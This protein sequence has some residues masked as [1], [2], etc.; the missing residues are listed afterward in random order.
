M[1]RSRWNDPEGRELDVLITIRIISREDTGNALN[2]LNASRA[3]RPHRD[4]STHASTQTRNRRSDTKNPRSNTKNSRPSKASRPNKNPRSHPSRQNHGNPAKKTARTTARGQLSSTSAI[5]S[6]SNLRQSQRSVFLKR[7]FE[8]ALAK[9]VGI[10]LHDGFERVWQLLA[11]PAL[12]LLMSFMDLE[13]FLH[14]YP[15]QFRTLD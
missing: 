4:P 12:R 6:R 10:W 15:G 1:A 3:T 2:K 14:Y 8:S 13:P 5:P 9:C 7:L 11:T